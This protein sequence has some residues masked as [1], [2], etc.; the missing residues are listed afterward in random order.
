MSARARSRASSGRRWISADRRTVGVVAAVVLGTFGLG[1]GVTALSFSGGAGVEVATVPDLRDMTLNQAERALDRSDLEIA[2]TDS[3][4]NPDT[5]AGAILA[6]S[7]LPGQEVSPGSE[8]QVFLSTGA[9]RPAVPSVSGMPLVLATRALQ[10]AGFEV[11]VE[12]AEGEGPR[13]RV[14]G[15]EPQAGSALRLPATVRLLVSSGPAMVEMPAVVGMA[16]DQARETLEAA[17]LSVTEILYVASD[18]E[19]RGSVVAQEPAPADSVLP[20][21]SVRLR[22]ANPD[23]PTT[24]QEDR[25]RERDRARDDRADPR[26]DRD[27]FQDRRD[28]PQRRGRPDSGRRSPTG[29]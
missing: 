7:P 13:G 8:V 15:T 19:A 6:Q 27:R 28:A 12:E 24:L 18:P 4:P 29:R 21:T 26:D 22:V 10:T 2:V 17:G 23:P 3:F 20:G 16:E 5:P 14:I 11:L 9:R 25:E 1:F